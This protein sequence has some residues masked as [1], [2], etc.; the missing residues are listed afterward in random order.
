MNLH[1]NGTRLF[2]A[3]AS[4][5]GAV[6]LSVAFVPVASAAPS[7]S[8]PG[9]ARWSTFGSGQWVPKVGDGGGHGPVTSSAPCATCAYGVTSGGASMKANMLPTTDPN[10]ITALSYDF[11]ANQTGNSGGSPRMVVE[12]S[13]GGNA[14]LRPLTWTA[15]T[16]THVD[17]ITGNNWDTTNIAG[18]PTYATTWTTIEG[19]VSGQSITAIFVVND[20]GWLYTS[21]EQVVLDNLTVNQTVA[22]GPGASS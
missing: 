2:A 10:A 7:G 1:V 19:C 6:G 3:L 12:F 11:E 17:G 15:D 13:G 16:W 14:Q 18:C 8:V 21:G 5:I 20:S 4:V 9:G 22:A